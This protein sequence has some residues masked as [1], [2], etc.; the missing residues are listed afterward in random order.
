MIFDGPQ[1]ITFEKA[2]YALLK[3]IIEKRGSL[4]C[5]KEMALGGA[6]ALPEV[7]R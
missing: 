4:L 3:L 5:A 6:R 1:M 7:I 2:K